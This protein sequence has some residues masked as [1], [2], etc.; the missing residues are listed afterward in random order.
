MICGFYLCRVWLMCGNF[1]KGARILANPWGFLGLPE[2]QE[3]LVVRFVLWGREP[4][5]R[6]ASLAAS[7]QRD[8]RQFEF[9][10]PPNS[11][12]E[13]L[14]ASIQW[15]S[16][17]RDIKV[18]ILKW[19]FNL[20]ISG[21]WQLLQQYQISCDFPFSFQVLKKGT[22]LWSWWYT[23]RGALSLFFHQ[24]TTDRWKY[25]K[26]LKNQVNNN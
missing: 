2:I 24:Q 20:N 21:F 26:L 13:F 17:A 12:W 7:G 19:T 5:W 8:L 22:P 3:F 15:C 4:T 11:M 16:A 14:C 10:D 18:S 6:Q 9:S 1:S 23:V 25:F